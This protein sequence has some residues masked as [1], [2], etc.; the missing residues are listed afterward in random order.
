[1]TSQITSNIKKFGHHIYLVQMDM[2]PRYAYTIGLF[3][4]LGVELVMPGSSF[5]SAEQLQTIINDTASLLISNEQQDLFAVSDVCLGKFILK[6]VDSSWVK[7][8]MFGAQDYFNRDDIKA[9]QIVP[10]KD[11]WTIDVPDLSVAFDVNNEPN[12]KWLDYEWEY[13][14]PAKA[15]AVTN[16]GALRG[17][18][19]TEASRW[20]ADEW[21]L[22]AGSGPDVSE[23]DM[24]VVPL[25]TLLSYDK[26][27]ENVA[28]LQVGKALW[29]DSEE[30]K[31]IEWN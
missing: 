13:N 17:G 22:F 29:R 1:M 23:E 16:L 5:Y 19:V 7:K 14:V 20:E 3:E 27:L 26:S 31:W 12:W 24:R 28:E 25:G 18:K 11:H 4:K 15:I 21:E 9:L 10:D 2:C 30:L 6:G 8:L